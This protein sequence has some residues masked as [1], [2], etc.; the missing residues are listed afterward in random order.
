[1]L[2]VDELEISMV[3]CNPSPPKGHKIIWVNFDHDLLT[4]GTNCQKLRLVVTQCMW[5][6]TFSH[7]RVSSG[8]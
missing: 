5:T 8:D 7:E 6:L 1:M 4:N 2:F 3:K